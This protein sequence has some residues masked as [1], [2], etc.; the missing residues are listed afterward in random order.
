MPLESQNLTISVCICSLN[1][2]PIIFQLL[3]K[4]LSLQTLNQKKWEIIIID[5]GSK[6]PIE[7]RFSSIFTWQPATRWVNEPIRGFANVRRRAIL[8]AHGE[9]IV[10]V[11]DDC[12]L[13]PEYLNQVIQ[14]FMEN[15]EVGIFTGSIAFSSQP[16]ANYFSRCIYEQSAFGSIYSGMYKTKENKRF[17]LATRGGAGMAMKKEIGLA[18]LSNFDVYRKLSNLLTL[19]KL[20]SLCFEDLDFDMTAIRMGYKLGRNGNLQLTHLAR[21]DDMKI[22][23]LTTRSYK[24]GFNHELF[25]L[26]WGWHNLSKNKLIDIIIFIKSC[27]WPRLPISRWFIRSISYAGVLF[28]KL[29]LKQNASIMAAVIEC[30]I[31]LSNPSNDQKLGNG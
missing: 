8:E 12:I 10:W 25:E 4:G 23:K 30:Q 21:Q 26:R 22:L 13:S 3:A 15:P 19:R 7:N 17:T 20:P 28:A 18:Y 9:I 31:E 2:D 11:D 14:L 5:N 1:P 24:M 16:G 29:V 6:E 27:G